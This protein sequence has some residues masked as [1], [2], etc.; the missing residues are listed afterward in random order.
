M[1][2][3]IPKPGSTGG[4]EGYIRVKT[5]GDGAMND[6]LLLLVQQCD[7]LLFRPDGVV[8]PAGRVVEEFYD[9][10]DFLLWWKQYRHIQKS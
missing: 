7:H 4:L 1:P 6:D 2:W 3:N 5:A 9:G 8:Q 10:A